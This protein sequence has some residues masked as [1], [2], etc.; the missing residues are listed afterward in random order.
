MGGAEEHRLS[1]RTARRQYPGH[2]EDGG[3]DGHAVDRVRVM[4]R[5]LT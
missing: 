5:S 2:T 1:A 4:L 3:D